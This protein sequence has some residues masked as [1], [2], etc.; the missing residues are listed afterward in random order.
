MLTNF[1]KHSRDLHVGRHICLAP[2]GLRDQI[3]AG[4]RKH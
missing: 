2:K 1:D 3:V 4:G